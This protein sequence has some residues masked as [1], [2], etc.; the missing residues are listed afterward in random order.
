VYVVGA[1]A[2]AMAPT[3]YQR[4]AMSYPLNLAVVV[5]KRRGELIRDVG[6]AGGYMMHEFPDN[7]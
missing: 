7:I 4:F 1:M 3:T 6:I 2:V 5:L